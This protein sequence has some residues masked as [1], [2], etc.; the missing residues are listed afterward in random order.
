[1]VT[2]VPPQNYG[3]SLVQIG[4][5]IDDNIIHQERGP[6]S[7]YINPSMTTFGSSQVG[8]ARVPFSTEHADT[9]VVILA[10]ESRI[11]QI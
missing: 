9:C 7:M 2:Y 4:A 3:R 10:G 5:S 11:K 8:W 1:M 6:S